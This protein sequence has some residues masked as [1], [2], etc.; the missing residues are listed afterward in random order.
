[1]WGAFTLKSTAWKP[2][3][4][5]RFCT[6]LFSREYNLAMNKKW[7]DPAKRLPNPETMETT[8]SFA[9]FTENM[10]KLMTVKP[11]KKPASPAPVSSS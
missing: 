10:R 7:Q 1:M 3:R 9:Q 5:V 6:D 8:G 2:F 11:E 4:S